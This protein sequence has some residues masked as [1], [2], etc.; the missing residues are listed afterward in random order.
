MHLDQLGVLEY[1]I[2]RLEIVL[3]IIRDAEACK[4][5][6]AKASLTR[7]LMERLLEEDIAEASLPSLVF[8]V[9]RHHNQDL[10][11]LRHAEKDPSDPEKLKAI[12]HNIAETTK[13]KEQF[14]TTAARLAEEL[15]ADS[16]ARRV[17]E[18]LTISDSVKNRAKSVYEASV[19]S[20]FYA[21]YSGLSQFVHGGNRET[22]VV[23]RQRGDLAP[24]LQS[25][26]DQTIAG[27][28]RHAETR[29][30]AL[31]NMPQAAQESLEIAPISDK[32]TPAPSA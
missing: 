11:F 13:L 25:V 17:Y 4:S 27:V 10:R 20:A 24:I 3:D 8:L 1:R 7:G 22:L 26:A 21:D 30:A 18:A 5:V 12:Q 2:R 31:R 16:R 19:F 23:T 32:S 28:K 15:P 29:L 14:L 9:A 6:Y